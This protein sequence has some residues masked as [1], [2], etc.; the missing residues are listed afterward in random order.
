MSF[1]HIWADT[2]HSVVLKTIKFLSRTT[3]MGPCVKRKDGIVSYRAQRL[4]A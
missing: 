4:M 1:W 3:E 2:F